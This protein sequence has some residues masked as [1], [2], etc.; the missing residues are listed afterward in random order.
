MTQEAT[1]DHAAANLEAVWRQTTSDFGGEGETEIIYE[2]RALSLPPLWVPK[3]GY[4]S[5]GK[6]ARER[7]R[8]SVATVLGLERGAPIFRVGE[9]WPNNIILVP[10]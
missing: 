5:K 10:L 7:R 9:R 4:K 3:L 8:G 2:A 6:R 1:D